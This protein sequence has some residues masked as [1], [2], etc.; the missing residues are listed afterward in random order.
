MLS[1]VPPTCKGPERTH[2]GQMGP[3]THSDPGGGQTHFS[4]FSLVTACPP[5]SH[6]KRGESRR[7]YWDEAKDNVEIAERCR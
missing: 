3:G 4:C 1:A 7:L 5:P 6:L 2:A